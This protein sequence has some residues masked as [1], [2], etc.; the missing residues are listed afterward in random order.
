MDQRILKL[1][2]QSSESTKQEK[3][4]HSHFGHPLICETEWDELLK[5]MTVEEACIEVN[6]RKRDR[7]AA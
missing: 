5:T 2:E 7:V 6:R 1:I 4:V 3:N